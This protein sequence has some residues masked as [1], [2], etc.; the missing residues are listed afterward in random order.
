[1]DEPHD[2][3]HLNGGAGL[4][5]LRKDGFASLDAV[6]GIGEI[7]TKRLKGAKGS[8][9]INFKTTYGWLKVEVLDA[10]GKV[11]PGYGKDDCDIL[12][13]DSI[14]QVVTWGERK[15][16]PANTD[17][18]RLHFLMKD[19]SL[20][21]FTAGDAVQVID[22]EPTEPILAVLCTFEGD[23]P[24]QA[25]DKL[26]EDGIQDIL[27]HG[28]VQVDDEPENAAFGEQSV[29]INFKTFRPIN[30]LEL[31]G[32][33]ELGTGFTLA[34]MVKSKDNKHARLFSNYDC[35]GPVNTSELV[36][37]CD[38]QGKFVAG[39]R[40]FCK[41]ISVES[42]PLNFADGKYHHVAV[43][44]DDGLVRFYLDGREVGGT[45]LPGGT[46]VLLKG[47]LLVGEDAELGSKEQFTGHMDDILVLG[48]ALSADEIKVLREKG[49]EAFF[50]EHPNHP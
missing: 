38:P 4:A 31:G 37:D 1:A 9:R 25:T 12:Q 35:C 48:R 10:D 14:D 50:K 8:L 36:F 27:F 11:L 7:L 28:Y 30:K 33:A 20:Y 46:P 40:L 24:K 2:M 26:P 5:T 21:S 3:F 18:I 6:Q 16:L 23:P 22:D 47:N 34:A 43:T 44:Y 42:E 39:L 49:A 13:G 29:E 19:V 32:T 41:G 15:E 45:R 17:P